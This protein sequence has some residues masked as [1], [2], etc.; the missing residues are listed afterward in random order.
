MSE[1]KL[2]IICSGGGMRCTFTAGAMVA[3]AKEFG[4][5][6]PDIIIAASGSVGT[7]YYY[8]AQQ[9]DALERVWTKHLATNKFI[10]LLKFW[11][12]INIDYLIDKV[13]KKIDPIN[14][15]S[16]KNSHTNIY[17]PLLNTTNG[18]VTYFN[19]HGKD[20]DFEIARAA[21]AMP[22]FYGKKIIINGEIWAD[23]ALTTSITNMV[24]KAWGLGATHIIVFDTHSKSLVFRISKNIFRKFVGIPTPKT[25]T[26]DCLSK[27]ITFSD[28]DIS[29]KFFTHNQ[30]TLHSIFNEGYKAVKESPDIGIFLSNLNFEI[31]EERLAEVK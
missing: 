2:A 26:F 24:Q 17:I 31:V 25:N 11:K 7:A 10:S 9:Y 28:K 5:T 16:A 20:N 12:I 18:K 29:T 15:T 1:R 6:T 3:L 23:G 22:L 21:M 8:C 19:S 27:K 14:L 30:N 13:V 4:V